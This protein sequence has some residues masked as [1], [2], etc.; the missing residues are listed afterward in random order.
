M[1]ESAS[2]DLPESAA[3]GQGSPPSSFSSVAS[4]VDSEVACAADFSAIRYGQCWE[5]A[6]VLLEALEVQPGDTCLSIA[7]AGDNTLALLTRA[8][9]RVIAL[10]LSAAQLACLE[11]RVAAYRALTHAELLELIGSTPS[12]RRHDLYRRCRGQLSPDVCRFWDTRADA[13]QAGIGGAGKFERYLALFSERVLPLVHSRARVERLLQGGTHEEREAFY[14]REWD[15]WRWR[16]M[17]RAFFS[18]PVMGRVGR[19]P[20]FFRYVHG[21]VADRILART[22]HALTVLD[23]AANPYVQWILTGR[24]TVA[25]PYALR[26]EHFQTI[27][28]RLDHLEWH[29]QSLEDYLGT[30]GRHT[31]DCFNLSDIFEYM[32]PESCHRVLEQ[33]A[34]AGGSGARL[35]YWNMLVPRRMPERLAGRL[36]S[37]PELAA[38]LHRSDKA[39]FYSAFVVEEVL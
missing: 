12:A 1:L 6:D 31:I 14:N 34:D 10:D 8:P 36:R 13:I 3:H 38:R 27:R 26:P 29:R 7:S 25:L 30:A 18:R 35:A 16:A 4:A 17:F 37:L 20:S 22:R 23:P 32:A 28:D 33:L 11:L 9:E 21:N 19:D 15:T 5:D 24:H 2:K 39:F